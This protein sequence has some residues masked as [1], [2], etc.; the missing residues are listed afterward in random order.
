MNLTQRQITLLSLA[1]T[2][3]YDKELTKSTNNT[4]KQEVMELSAILSKEY[5][6]SLYESVNKL[7]E[8]NK[9]EE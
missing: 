1:L 8:L 7:R 9:R 6:K 4:M 5:N 2:N 3:F